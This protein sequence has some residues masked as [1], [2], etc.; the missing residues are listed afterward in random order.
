MPGILDKFGSHPGSVVPVVVIA[1]VVVP[2]GQTHEIT[3]FETTMAG[4]GTNMIVSVQTSND[5]FV[6]NIVERA[7]TEMPS[8][9]TFL[10]TYDSS[11]AV[12]SGLSW[13]VV[14]SQGVASLMSVRCAGQTKS[15]DFS[16]GS[17]V[18]G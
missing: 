1:P 3:E 4:A 6:L 9:G 7:R 5:G 11:I 2:A 17:D 16:P 15:Q 14:M 10:K 13:R 12:T 8:G 18:I